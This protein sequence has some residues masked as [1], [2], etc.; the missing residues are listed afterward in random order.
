MWTIRIL[1]MLYVVNVSRHILSI[2][3]VIYLI[4]SSENKCA[5]SVPFLFAW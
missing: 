3:E 5:I 2:S 1:Q 4:G